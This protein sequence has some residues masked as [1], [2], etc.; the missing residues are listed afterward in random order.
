[1]KTKLFFV[2]E[3]LGNENP[4]IYIVD[5]NTGYKIAEMIDGGPEGLKVIAM[6]LAAAPEL[7]AALET[8]L[9]DY[10]AMKEELKGLRWDKYRITPKT[11]IS[12]PIL[13]AA[14]DAI[15]KAKGEL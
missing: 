15:A 14:K 4:A 1:M 3:S 10:I 12:D 7:L 8:I 2:D 9:P 11:P 13:I 5:Q 6:L